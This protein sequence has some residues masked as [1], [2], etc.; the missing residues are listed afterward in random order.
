M[1]AAYFQCKDV[2]YGVELA[3]LGDLRSC[4]VGPD[5][6]FAGLVGSVGK[7][8]ANSLDLNLVQVT[9]KP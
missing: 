7:A 6:E 2:A 5:L 9:L 4:P 1:L 8:P 3:V